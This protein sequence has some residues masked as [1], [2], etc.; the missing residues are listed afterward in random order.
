MK[1][2]PTPTPETQ[3]AQLYGVMPVLEAL[4]A[5]RRSINQITLAEGVKD[6]R[7]HEIFTLARQLDVPVR[8]L[9]RTE[10]ARLVNGAN[11]QGV[12][13]I[14]AAASYA[15]ADQLL[16]ALTNAN[17][18]A[19]GLVLDGVEDPRNLGAIIRTAECAGAH[20]IF[21]PER[22]AVGLTETVAKAS[23]GALEHLPVA[24]VTNLT[25]L[26]EEMKKRGIWTIGTDAA[27]PQSYAEWDWTQPCAIVLGGEGAGLHR[28]VR[29]TCD[30]LVSLPLFGK[31]SSLNVSV[32]AGVLLYE[33]RRQ[34]LAANKKG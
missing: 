29:E 4:R 14:L 9:P 30:S 24:R 31:I 32:A 33:A 22:R 3:P 25:R 6:Q 1:P 23:A 5:G 27:A 13:A 12:L 15:D 28:L 11:H 19:L 20:G 26:L 7:L 18:P 16:D 2:K 34:R 10:L 21:V 17:E 8:R